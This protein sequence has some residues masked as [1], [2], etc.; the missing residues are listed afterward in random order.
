MGNKVKYGLKN[1]HYA[2]ATIAADGTATFSKPK[3]WPGAVSLSLDPEGEVTKFY[4]D[5]VAYSQYAINAGYSGTYES[6]L[7]PED[8]RKDILGDLEDTNGV[9]LEDA[10]AES[11]HFALLFEFSGD[12]E[13]VRHVMYNCV[14]SRPSVSGETKEEGADPQTEELEIT[15]GTIRVTALD[16]D[17]PKARVGKDSLKYAGWYDEVYVSTGLAV[18]E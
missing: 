13:S 5:D 8:F 16:K 18:T 14:A 17:I 1:V 6:A 12:V 2:A 7:I 15:C 11:K 10:A 3:R 9:I 4:A